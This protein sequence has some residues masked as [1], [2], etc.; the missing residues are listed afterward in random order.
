MLHL[1]LYGNGITFK[2]VV[3]SCG[4]MYNKDFLYSASNDHGD[5]GAC[6]KLCSVSKLL[7][8]ATNASIFCIL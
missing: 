7:P 4:L 5:T 1:S 3:N 2:Q 8:I 6:T